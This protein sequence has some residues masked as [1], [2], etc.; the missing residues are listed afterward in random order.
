MNHQFRGS[1]FRI[2]RVTLLVLALIGG[3]LW[4]RRF[5]TSLHSEQ[6]VINAEIVQ[7]RTPIT[8]VLEIEDVRPGMLLKKG[9]PIF[10][11]T[12]Q[13]FGDRE[14][15]AQYNLLQAQVETLRSELASAK[16]DLEV[17]EAEQK[18]QREYFQRGIVSR[19][20]KETAET[21]FTTV[22]KLVE[23]KREQLEHV[24]KRAQEME[25][26]MNLEKKSE[27]TAPED[28]LIWSIAGK[29]GEQVNSNTLIMEVIN[30]SRIWVD[31]FF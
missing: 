14:A 21:S 27:M 3:A 15:V 23:N 4:L 17:D 13:R 6:A 8:G 10:K 29:S 19:I 1:L 11:V 5:I 20:A 12:N 22:Q 7:I 24:E 25:A 18:K 9:D 16:R 30:P 26:Q 31:A 2:L 28:G